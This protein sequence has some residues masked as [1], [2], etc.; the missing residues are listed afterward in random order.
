MASL[1]GALWRQLD[2]VAYEH[3]G[4]SPLNRVIVA[5]IL[6]SV[7]AGIFETEPTI[8]TLAPR[9]FDGLELGFGII[10]LFEYA[11]RLWAEGENERFRGIVGRLRYMLTP[12]ALIDLTVLMPS[13]I[14]P[15][16]GNVMVLRTFRLLRILRLARL[17]RFSSALRHLAVAF[18]ERREELFLS[19]ALAGVVLIFSASAMYL[20]EGPAQ[21]E[22]FGSVPRALWWSICTLTTVGYGDIYPHTVLG[23]ICS[24]ITSLAG[25]GLIAMPAGI[26]AA[27]FSDAFQRNRDHRRE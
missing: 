18:H 15:G 19:M 8:E 25:I 6:L 10:F 26:L 5:V 22:A 11:A 21:P 4:L 12:A 14:S 7:V 17:G 3:D 27:A 1:R 20:I 24:G 16:A 2:P 9:S 23:K 13:L